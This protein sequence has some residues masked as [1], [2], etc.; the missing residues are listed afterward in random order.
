MDGYLNQSRVITYTPGPYKPGEIPKLEPD[1]PD[2]IELRRLVHC[3]LGNDG[4]GNGF[5]LSTIF[6][7]H[8]GAELP[9]SGSNQS[10]YADGQIEYTPYDIQITTDIRPNRRVVQ[11][12][13]RHFNCPGI[14]SWA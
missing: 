14:R 4:K 2:K 3:N 9:D 1:I 12:G 6:D 8:K 5:H 11:K 13:F 7:L 10:G